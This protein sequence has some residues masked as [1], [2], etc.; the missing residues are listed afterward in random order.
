MDTP[1]LME[2]ILVALKDLLK[3]KI[4]NSVSTGDKT[5][6]NLI[7]ALLL[8]ILTFILAKVN[9]NEITYLL[10]RYVYRYKTLDYKTL[11]YY[12]ILAKRQKANF[13]YVTWST[14]GYPT[15]T[16]KITEVYS[17]LHNVGNFSDPGFYNPRKKHIYK[18][19]GSIQSNFDI[20][21]LGIIRENIVPIYA[22]GNSMV[23]LYK[24]VNDWIYIAYTS[25]HT[26]TE[27]M[28]WMNISSDEKIDS[29]SP[30][31]K[32]IFDNQLRSIGKIYTDRTIDLFVSRHKKE[33]VAAIDNFI[34]VNAGKRILGGY[35]S[36]N[37]GFMLY[38]A[39]GTGKT[40]LI[41]AL[42]NYLDKN[43]LMIDMRKIKTRAK[44]EE[45][46]TT[47]DNKFIYCLDEFDCVQGAI[48]NREISGSA[49]VEF[50]SEID[51]L[52]A[53][54]LELFKIN[55]P[56]SPAI[57]QELA[58]IDARISELENSITLDTILTV[59]DGVNEM[60]GRIIIA[61][62]N[63]LESIDPALLRAGRFDMKIKLG[64][65]NTQ[66]IRDMLAIMYKNAITPKL[67]K[68]INET[69]FQ[70]DRFA[71]VDIIYHASVIKNIR[72]LINFL[73]A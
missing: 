57:D 54:Q 71:P 39:P 23:C 56:P 10:C 6:D 45:L 5:Q 63:H 40:M 22:N 2:S 36:F 44:F 7:T 35:E 16:E 38:G 15:F 12:K 67:Q 47:H 49:D 59:L 62:T 52:K 42:A 37:L 58:K 60:R 26:L 20:V 32:V 72:D 17:K 31:Q 55:T 4:V 65:F 41:K 3:F 18:E 68:L 8:T 29:D 61:T 30:K 69:K 64:K 43:V 28:N 34:S 73:K 25:E 19:N 1:N 46:F 33:I 66:E 27:F 70:E 9:A 51:N 11:D 24:H 13:A 50:V 14:T 21:R 48:K 53:R